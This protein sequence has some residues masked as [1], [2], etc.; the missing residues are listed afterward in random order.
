MADPAGHRRTLSEACCFRIRQW[1]GLEPTVN[2]YPHTEISAED[3]E[4][5]RQAVSEA[6]A[7]FE[8]AEFGILAAT[9]DQIS[10]I[11]ILLATALKIVE[12]S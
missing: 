10:R 6:G 11:R 8:Q 2:E 3:H 1:T 5:I 9:E 12:A 7:Y 4:K